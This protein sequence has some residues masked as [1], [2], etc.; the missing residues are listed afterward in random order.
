MVMVRMKLH[1]GISSKRN[2]FVG[3]Q[4]HFGLY[5]LYQ[6]LVIT[7]SSSSSHACTLSPQETK[8]TLL[9]N[10][11][12]NFDLRYWT[13]PLLVAAAYLNYLTIIFFVNFS[14]TRLG[15]F[16]WYLYFGMAHQFACGL[17]GCNETFTKKDNLYRHFRT[18]HANL[19]LQDFGAGWVRCDM[20]QKPFSTGSALKAHR[21]ACERNVARADNNNLEVGANNINPGVN[22]ANNNNNNEVGQGANGINNNEVGTGAINEPIVGANVNNN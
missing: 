17:N 13:L 15:V 12:T 16:K 18:R 7:V 3:F 22:G 5:G 10:L 14:L 11:A 21:K 2:K 8:T 20:C 4:S 19:P 6:D 9:F 1:I